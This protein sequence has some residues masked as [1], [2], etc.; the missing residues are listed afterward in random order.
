M[1]ERSKLTQ[2]PGAV[3]F[4][5]R[6]AAIG[7]GTTGIM[8]VFPNLTGATFQ[9]TEGYF[10]PDALVTGAGT[11]NMSLAIQNRGTAGTGTTAVT[12]TLAFSSASVT[13][14]QAA[15]KAFTVSATAANLL[16]ANGE[17]LA[18]VKTEAGSGLALPAGV[19]VV[20]GRFV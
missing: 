14:A 4:T 12:S 9:V 19:V 17:T 2:L 11:N 18:L 1:S 8:P 5:A 20:K 6:T 16:I 13:A 3:Q 7:A 10:V 15:Q